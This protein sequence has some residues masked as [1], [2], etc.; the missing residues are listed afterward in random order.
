M[1]ACL[2]ALCPGVRFI[3]MLF[4]AVSF[5]ASTPAQSPS[6]PSVDLPPAN[7]PAASPSPEKPPVPAAPLPPIKAA[8]QLYREGKFSEAEAAY[9]AILKDD[10]ASSSAYVGLA[11]V[12]LKQKRV[13]AAADSVAKAVK[14]SPNSDEVQV[15]QGEL[16]FRQGHIADAERL[17]TP[18]IRKGAAGDARANLGLGRVYWVSSYYRHAK[19]Q[20]DLAYEKDKDDPDIR[21]AWMNTLSLKER[22]S[23]LRDYL[24]GD[25]D[26]DEESREHMHAG[27]TLL[28]D[29]EGEGRS[30]CHI[31]SRPAEVHLP[32]ERL[33]YSAKNIRGYGLKL[34][35]N[36]VKATL[37]LDTGASG[38]VISRKVAERAGIK[39]IV[40]SDVHGIG[41]KGPVSSF[42]GIADSMKVGGLELQGCHVS[43]IER[44]SVAD[45]DGLIG[46]DV[47]S[48]Y[49]VN[50]NFP[51]Y[52]FELTALPPRPPDS[53]QDKALLA[54]F[55]KIQRFHD[56]F[57]PPEMKDWSPVYRFGHMLLIPT[58]IND[59]PTL[60]L[61]LI[62]TGAFSD[63]ISPQVAR[64]FTK[65]HDDDHMKVK[66]LNGNVARVFSADEIKLQFSHFRQPAVGMVAF[67]TSHISDRAGTEISGMLG[68]AMLYQ[69]QLK[70]DYRDGLVDFVYDPNRFH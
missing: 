48:S 19:L 20:F 8:L 37:L 30:G 36:G 43:V 66:G 14:L 62:D 7:A 17:F 69:M 1:R 32:M 33:M 29:A 16:A 38:I 41:D 60:N 51:D 25:S 50:I 34:D 23:A 9:S 6:Q 4:F 70:I 10:P 28:E 68:F 53:E 13:D 22:V 12:Q 67:D 31:V 11:R 27:L 57:T 21:R 45:E 44:N 56:R 40:S 63:T 24:S 54:K 64:Q 52:K 65:V 42:F 15:M 35:V 59:A 18:I 26:D 46:A 47:F 5:S 3:A 49:L 55:P 39:S 2:A 58:R 61:F